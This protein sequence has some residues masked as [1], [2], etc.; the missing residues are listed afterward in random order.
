M[1]GIRP[2]GLSDDEYS[3]DDELIEFDEAVS[4]QYLN[5]DGASATLQQQV[6]SR[7][8]SGYICGIYLYT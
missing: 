1:A 8:L 2:S 5:L 6:R 4:K 3:D 7:E